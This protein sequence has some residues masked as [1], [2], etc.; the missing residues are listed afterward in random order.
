M[1]AGNPAGYGKFQ[2]D[3]DSFSQMPP[4]DPNGFMQI[5]FTSGILSEYQMDLIRAL[6]ADPMA[7][8]AVA[9]GADPQEALSGST[10][11][12]PTTQA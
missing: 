11:Q 1:P 5:L 9:E 2:Q 10:G 3:Y 12:Q 8:Q 7:A 4:P 6:M